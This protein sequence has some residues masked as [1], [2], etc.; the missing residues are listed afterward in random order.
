MYFWIQIQI[1]IQFQ[2][3]VPGSSEEKIMELDQVW[4]RFDPDHVNIRPDLRPCMT[5]PCLHLVSGKKFVMKEVNI[6]STHF[7]FRR[8]WMGELVSF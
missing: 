2:Y 1:L 5:R 7:S 6:L 8:T 4:I 3:P